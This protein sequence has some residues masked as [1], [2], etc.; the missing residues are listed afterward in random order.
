MS[1]ILETLKFLGSSWLEV[2]VAVDK[3]LE[4][5]AAR[6]AEL[7]A[8]LDDALTYVWRAHGWSKLKPETQAYK[9]RKKE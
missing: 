6:I 2:A 5:Q 4:T 9:F 3:R 1:G 8:A 7:E